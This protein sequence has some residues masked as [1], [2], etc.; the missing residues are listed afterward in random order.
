MRSNVLPSGIGRN[1]PAFT[2]LARAYKQLNAPVGRFGLATLA[3]SNRAITGD[4]RT[5]NRL[6]TRLTSLGSQRDALAAQIIQKL[7]AAEFNNRPLDWPSTFKLLLQ[8][9]RLLDR[10][11]GD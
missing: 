6:E 2:L 11:S 8:A 1:P 7:E 3:T 10:A 9:N 5:Y 4:D